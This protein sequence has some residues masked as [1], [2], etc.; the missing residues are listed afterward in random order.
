MEKTLGSESKNLV[1]I[2]FLCV[3]SG[4]SHPPSGLQ[5]LSGQRGGRAREGWCNTGL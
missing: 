2:Q 4:K 5:N 3:T 1:P